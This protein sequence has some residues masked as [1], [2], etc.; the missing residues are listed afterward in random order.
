MN[1]CCFVELNAIVGL[2]WLHWWSLG[3]PSYPLG[4]CSL[5]SVIFMQYLYTV[6]VIECQA[7]DESVWQQWIEARGRRD[8]GT[9]KAHK[10][11]TWRAL[12]DMLVGYEGC[13][14]WSLDG[15]TTI[16]NHLILDTTSSDDPLAAI[17]NYLHGRKLIKPPAA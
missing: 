11:S 15:S 10:P 13:W 12:Q 3:S 8:S 9:D 4:A 5:Y 16:A 17:M 2:A 14:K 6:V 1:H 7:S